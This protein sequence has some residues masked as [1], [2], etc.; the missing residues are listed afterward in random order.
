MHEMHINVELTTHHPL[1]FG[2]G[3][4]APPFW[5]TW[6]SRFCFRV[7]GCFPSPPLHL[8]RDSHLPQWWLKFKSFHLSNVSPSYLVGKTDPWSGEEKDEAKLV[9]NLSIPLSNAGLSL[10]WH[11]GTETLIFGPTNH[12]PPCL[13][14]VSISIWKNTGWRMEILGQPRAQEG[15]PWLVPNSTA[16][17]GLATRPLI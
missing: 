17:H 10:N 4:A 16:S 13:L 1:Q 12:S 15:R 9:C 3:I 14:P 11:V 6:P 2:L 5:P 7:E 8:V